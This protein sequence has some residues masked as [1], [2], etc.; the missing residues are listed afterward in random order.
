MLSQ[1]EKA[2]GGS[3]DMKMERNPA[4]ECIEMNKNETLQTYA[5]L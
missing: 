2:V 4:Y 5:N 1:E 3:V